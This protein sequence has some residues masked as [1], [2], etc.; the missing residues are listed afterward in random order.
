MSTSFNRRYKRN[1]E[2]LKKKINEQF[3]KRIQGK[4]NEEIAVIMEQIKLKYGFDEPKQP[5]EDLII[6]PIDINVQ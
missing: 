1:Q 6:P 2:R 5:T 3:F 4:S